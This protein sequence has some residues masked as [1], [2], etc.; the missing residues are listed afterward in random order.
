[1]SHSSPVKKIA[2]VNP[3]IQRGLLESSE[4][5][6]TYR[7]IAA[8]KN[9]GIEA[10]S[11]SQQEDVYD[12]NPDFVIPITW[13]EPKLTH[14]PTYG[15]LIMPVKWITCSPRFM[16]NVMTYDGYFSVSTSVSEWLYKICL[17]TN[18]PFYMTDALFTVPKTTF[19]ELDFNNAKAAYLGVNW[20]G[21]RH[22]AL[23][24]YF[25]DG[26]NLTCF[27][28]KASWIKYPANLY[29]G[30]VPFDG[31]SVLDT[32]AKNG[33]GLCINHPDADQDGIPTCRI[34][35][36]V[37]AS[38]IAIC[39]DNKYYQDHFG[40]TVL[41][42]NKN[43]PTKDLADAIKEKIDWVRQH[44]GDARDMAKMAHDIFCRN[45]A[46]EVMIEKM[47]GLHQG[48]IK[49]AGFIRNPA[50]TAPLLK[51]KL[52]YLIYTDNENTIQN[53]IKD[54]Q[55]QS[56]D[57]I[58]VVLLAKTQDILN[59]LAKYKSNNISTLLYT[60]PDHNRELMQLLKDQHSE[61]LCILKN[62]DRI[63][64]NHA[65]MLI[66]AYNKSPHERALE[67]T[68]V[69]FSN[70]LEHSIANN[71]Q[72]KIQDPFMLYLNNKSR[73]GNVL[74]VGE[75][76]LC[77]VTFKLTERMLQALTNTDF[78]TSLRI[79]YAMSHNPLDMAIHA[80][81]ILSSSS[82]EPGKESVLI[83]HN[84]TSIFNFNNQVQGQGQLFQDERQRTQQ[85]LST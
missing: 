23:F 5:E 4:V 32:Y 20:D 54:I 30:M 58:S 19:K 85:Q 70:S 80:N 83:I 46:S 33:I 75:I 50:A 34:F 65:A 53:L 1:M 52:T 15:L 63:F 16:R 2:I 76:P 7:F 79:D 62:E 57:N 35:E 66:N 11:F 55:S 64:T 77:A 68:V 8:A 24:E 78:T 28:P 44:P 41:Y 9:I 61:W 3:Y 82:V 38:A 84:A 31:F 26:K 37:A 13:Q 51:E 45:L 47:V 42:V 74:P 60:G 21:L 81:L 71:L 18:K 59:Q 14:Y 67:S 49:N 25:A 73:V 10:V 40:D 17:M 69:V 29:G 12:F 6:A 72:D 56:Y 22:H 27:G 39:S 43:L 36:I 48:V